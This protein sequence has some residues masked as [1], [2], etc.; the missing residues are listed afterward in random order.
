MT[1]RLVQLTLPDGAR[2]VATLAEDG[3][4]W[5]KSESTIRMFERRGW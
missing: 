2:A 1:L 4:A 5:L 3:R